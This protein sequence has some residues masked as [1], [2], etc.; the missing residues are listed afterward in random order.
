[1]ERSIKKNGLINLLVLLAATVATFV[2]ARTSHALA[3]M[4]ATSFMA[5]GTLV[6]ALSWFQMRLEERE[7]VEKLE[8]D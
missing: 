7:R 2:L 6:A 3:A 4:I 1:M 5:I 8:Y